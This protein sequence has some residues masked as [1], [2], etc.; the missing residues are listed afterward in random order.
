MPHVS[1]EE[2]AVPRGY[3]GPTMS[4]QN[5]VEEEERPVVLV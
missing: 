4:V 3:F 2:K 5:G 1:V